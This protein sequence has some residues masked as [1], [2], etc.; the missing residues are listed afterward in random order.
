MIVLQV[1]VLVIAVVFHE[2]AHGYVAY[3]LGDFTAYR[4]GR[5]SLNPVRH[6]DPVGS[7]LVPFLLIVTGAPFLLGWAKPVPINPS[8]FKSPSMGMLWVALAGP[9]TNIALALISKILLLIPALPILVKIG[10]IFS[11]QL[12]TCID[13]Y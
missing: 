5:L 13:I 4:Q 1:I 10:L 9:A 11:I 12:K 3:R 2:V 6:I 8:V 7:L